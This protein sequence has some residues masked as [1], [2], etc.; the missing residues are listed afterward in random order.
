MLTAPQAYATTGSISLV[1]AGGFI[2]INNARITTLGVQYAGDYYVVNVN[3]Q[4]AGF[5]EP[6]QYTNTISG[7]LGATSFFNLGVG[8]GTAYLA[9][10]R[11]AIDPD[12]A[13]VLAGVKTADNILKTV[14]ATPKYP[15]IIIN[16][17]G[18][19]GAAGT[20]NN[21][22]VITSATKIECAALE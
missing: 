13:A 7:V 19:N 10:P 11:A 20:T 4:T 8:Y 15:T 9:I 16:F 14:S 21:N 1:N 3:T 2:T 17:I 6:M 5:S 18:A 12:C 22:I